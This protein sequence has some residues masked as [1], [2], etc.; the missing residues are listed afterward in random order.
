[1]NDKETKDLVVASEREN[2]LNS[3]ESSST[4]LSTLTEEERSHV[5]KSYNKMKNGFFSSVPMICKG[6][7]CFARH[8]CPFY[9][10]KKVPLDNQCLV[11]I[12]LLNYHIKKY[13]EEYN[14][15]PDK[16]HSELILLTEL[17]ECIIYEDRATKI[18]ANS[19]ASQ[20]MLVQERFANNGDVYEESEESYNYIV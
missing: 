10:I 12:D 17:A 4:F 14:L 2:W 15:N 6:D 1:M 16:N 8:T 9:A 19:D 18:L 11:E 20:M 13:A 3:I 7:D 5:E